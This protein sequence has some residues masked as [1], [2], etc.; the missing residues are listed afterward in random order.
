MKKLL[1]T[2]TGNWGV[3]DEELVLN[4]VSL[5]CLWNV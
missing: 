3:G 4:G 1:F 2:K 5:K